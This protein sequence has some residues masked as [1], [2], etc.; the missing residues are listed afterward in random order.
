MAICASR[1]VPEDGAD[2]VS[3]AECERVAF[4]ELGVVPVH[5]G[6]GEDVGA[7]G[8]QIRAGSGGA[9]QQWLGTYRPG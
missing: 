7:G 4:V 8:R 3:G 1:N 9:K 6:Q 2:T 5:L